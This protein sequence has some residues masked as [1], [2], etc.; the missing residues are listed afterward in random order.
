LVNKKTLLFVSIANPDMAEGLHN[1]VH[2]IFYRPIDTYSFINKMSQEFANVEQTLESA[3]KKVLVVEDDELQQLILSHLLADIDIA[4]DCV[5]SGE[6][7]IEYIEEHRP[8]VVFMDCIMP[9]MG[10]IEATRII[11]ENSR[12]NAHSITIIGATGLTGTKDKKQ[13]ID[14]GMDYVVNKPYDDDEI[15]KVLQNYMAIK[16]IN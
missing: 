16:K 12:N 10:G 6:K 2:H 11:K 14:A 8:D 5:D 9:G 13:C 4:T 15:K 3:S 1:F 7:A